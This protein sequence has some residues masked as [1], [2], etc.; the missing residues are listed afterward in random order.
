[1]RSDF[2]YSPI[3]HAYF[4]QFFTHRNEFHLSKTQLNNN[5]LHKMIPI[6]YERYFCLQCTFT[7]PMS[8]ESGIFTIDSNDYRLLRIFIINPN[9]SLALHIIKSA[10]YR[11]WCLRD[12]S[13]SILHWSPVNVMDVKIILIR[14]VIDLYRSI[15]IKHHNDHIY[16]VPIWILTSCFSLTLWRTLLYFLLHLLIIFGDPISILCV[17]FVYI[18]KM[19]RMSVTFGFFS[20]TTTLVFK[21]K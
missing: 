17:L 10:T 11:R 15:N 1:M 14:Y 9:I 16:Y 2:K 6:D 21:T 4:H 20:T 8:L 13:I 7:M 3:N 12:L 18:I 5:N 19:R